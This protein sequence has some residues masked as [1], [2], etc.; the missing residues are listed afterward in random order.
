[1][2]IGDLRDLMKYEPLSRSFVK[3]ASGIRSLAGFGQWFWCECNEK[4]ESFQPCRQAF[5]G[6]L[7]MKPVKVVSA[8][9]PIARTSQNHR[10]NHAEKPMRHSYRRFLHSGVPADPIK[11]R[12]EECALA[13]NASRRPGRLNQCSPHI[14]VAFAGASG[15]PFARALC[16]S[17]A[18]STPAGQMSGSRKPAHI[19]TDLRN[20]HPRR[21][22]LDSRD[23]AQ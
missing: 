7:G 22:P 2:K 20:N 16:I 17:R 9:L 13:V 6:P 23:L 8:L 12:G 18:Q 4:S 11:Q 5:S 10:V 21:E 14:P 3:Q 19:H 15:M 1:M